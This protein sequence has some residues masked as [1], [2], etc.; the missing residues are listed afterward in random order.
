MIM[1]QDME[2]LKK[3][4]LGTVIRVFLGTGISPLTRKKVKP[5]GSVVSDH[6]LLCNHSPSFE[7]AST[8]SL[9]KLQAYS[10]L[11]Y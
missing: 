3:V 2:G 9:V 4:F 10:L 11:V 1:V 6:L 7:N 8:S 5:K